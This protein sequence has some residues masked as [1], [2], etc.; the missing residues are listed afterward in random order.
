M[1]LCKVAS[2]FESLHTCVN[3]RTHHHIDVFAHKVN[4]C[5][6]KD[7]EAYFGYGLLT[8]WLYSIGYALAVTATVMRQMK[9][10]WSE[11]V[12]LDALRHR[13]WKLTLQLINAYG[14]LIGEK[15]LNQDT[16]SPDKVRS[17]SLIFKN[18]N[19]QNVV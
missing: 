16:N 10:C 4:F 2:K 8:R 15:A 9:R 6:V 11:D 5:N 3:A 1:H 17:L 13:F 19:P 18:N 7:S 14:Y 12:Y